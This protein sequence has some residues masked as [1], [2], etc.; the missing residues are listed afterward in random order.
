MF[1][2]EIFEKGKVLFCS[3]TL[4]IFAGATSLSSFGL[5]SPLWPPGRQAL[6]FTLSL[7]PL[8]RKGIHMKFSKS[9]VLN[10]VLAI[11]NYLTWF[12]IFCFSVDNQLFICSLVVC[13]G[14]GL[15]LV[16]PGIHLGLVNCGYT[17]AS[18]LHAVVLYLYRA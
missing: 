18:V 3:E 17:S 16:V 14:G 9:I 15:A 4:S 6:L 11:F 8:F 12:F 2:Y 10:Q 5:P 7:H 1:F 13:V